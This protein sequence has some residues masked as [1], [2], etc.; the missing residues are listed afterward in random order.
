M[1][2]IGINGSTDLE[3]LCSV[4]IKPRILGDIRNEEINNFKNKIFVTCPKAF[5]KGG[6][7][8][9]PPDFGRSEGAAL[10]HAPPDF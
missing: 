9:A 4:I 5:G 10:L 6:G 7:A 1:Y 2:I 3:A 8:Y